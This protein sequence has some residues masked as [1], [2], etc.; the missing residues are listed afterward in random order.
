[1][2]HADRAAANV[3]LILSQRRTKSATSVR[4]EWRTK[5]RWKSSYA[6]R[7]HKIQFIVGS[8]WERKDIKPRNRQ[9]KQRKKEGKTVCMQNHLQL[10]EFLFRR[11]VSVLLGC[12][13]LSHSRACIEMTKWILNFACTIRWTSEQRENDQRK[14][15]K[16]LMKLQWVFVCIL[17]FLSFAFVRL[18]SST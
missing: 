15:D 4:F 8:G 2:L 18:K 10:F 12:F 5:W 7:S 6:T 16:S 14:N 1:M 11:R 3:H 17:P 9:R 13:P